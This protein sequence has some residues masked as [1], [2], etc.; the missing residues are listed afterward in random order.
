MRWFAPNRGAPTQR[1]VPS[2]FMDDPQRW[3]RLWRGR[4][5]TPR[6]ASAVQITL[7]V[8]SDEIRDWLTT[9]AD[10]LSEI[11]PFDHFAEPVMIAV[12]NDAGWAA[13]AS[14][15]CSA[16]AR[17]MDRGELPVDRDGCFGDELL[18]A[19][20][21]LEAPDLL[22]DNPTLFDGLPVRASDTAWGSVVEDLD[23][24]ARWPA[25]QIPLMDAHPH[26]LVLLR[27]MPP[28]R[29]W[30]EPPADFGS[31]GRR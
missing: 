8:W 11:R 10:F 15:R 13:A 4:V 27:A 5:F 19:A 22:A 14:A 20:A 2:P 12:G 17:A 24:A 1:P 28:A 29:W 21:L 30:T 9:R 16:V 26:L 6:Q 7:T 31:N 23:D 18:L 25:W 3:A